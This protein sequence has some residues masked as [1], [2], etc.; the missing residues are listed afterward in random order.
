MKLRFAL[1]F[2]FVLALLPAAADAQEPD[3]TGFLGSIERDLRLDAGDRAGGLVVINADAIIEGTVVDFAVIID[4]TATVTGTGA[5][6]GQITVINGSL[7]LQ[8]GALVKD[9]SLIDSTFDSATNARVTGEVDERGEFV[10]RGFGTVF[11]IMFW[12]AFTIVLVAGAL[13]FAAVGGSQLRRAANVLTSEVGKTLIAA[14]FVWIVLPIVAILII[15]TVVGIGLGISL[16]IY[17]LP[18]L[19]FLGYIVAGTRLGLWIMGMTNRPSGGHPYL[20]AGLGVLLLQLV[21]WIP[22]LGWLL[23][24]IAGS[25]GAGAIL[26]IA[27]RAVRG[28]SGPSTA[29]ATPAV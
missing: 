14:V 7:V 18:S 6:E 27:W 24:A 8:D 19:W 23:A 5:V 29:P 4:G 9:V 26:L 21:T 2:S 17:V 1:I 25:V 11:S 28:G 15:F 22:F 12:I 10:F 3:S 20:A 16:L 13:A